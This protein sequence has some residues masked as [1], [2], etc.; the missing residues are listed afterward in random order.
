MKSFEECFRGYQDLCD[1]F[2]RQ[3][4]ILEIGSVFGL[5]R[6]H[7]FPNYVHSPPGDHNQIVDGLWNW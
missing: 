3:E 6:M 2:F 4:E 5:D 1:I 7:L